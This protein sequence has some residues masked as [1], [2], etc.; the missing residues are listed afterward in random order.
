MATYDAYALCIA[1]GD[2]HSMGISITLEGPQIA[3]QSIAEKFRGK[4][5]PAN[6]AGLKDARVYCP[7]LGR[8]Y[9]QR[10]NEQI[11]LISKGLSLSTSA[12]RAP[13]IVSS[14]L[15][16]KR[17]HCSREIG[18]KKMCVLS[19][20]VN[21]LPVAGHIHAQ[22]ETL[23][24]QSGTAL[25]SKICATVLVSKGPISNEQAIGRE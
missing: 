13:P 19:A 20:G 23:A 25:R 16:P 24:S 9:G 22:C 8:H 10:D 14:R 17:P 21:R 18:T 1:C 7:K 5:L 3:K 11:F 2:L 12:T 6:I 15:T 4:E